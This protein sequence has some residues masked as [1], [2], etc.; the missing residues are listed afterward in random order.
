MPI[1]LPDPVLAGFDTRSAKERVSHSPRA[2]EE[3]RRCFVTVALL[4]RVPILPE[5]GYQQEINVEVR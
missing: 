3:Q 4:L 2:P 5:P 1:L